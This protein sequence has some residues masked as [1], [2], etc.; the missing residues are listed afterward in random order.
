MNNS[1]HIWI[2]GDSWGVPNYCMPRPGFQSRYHISEMLGD[3]GYT[4]TN[5]AE[6]CAGNLHSIQQ[7]EKMISIS[8]FADHNP[9]W[10]IWFHTGILRDSDQ[11]QAEICNQLVPVSQQIYS[12]AAA[13]VRHTGAG[14]VMIE[15]HSPLVQDVFQEHLC[16]D[17]LISNWRGQIL[18]DPD[19]PQSHWYTLYDQLETNSGLPQ[20]QVQ[21]HIQSIDTMT[22]AMQQSALFPDC[23]HPG[24][25]AHIRLLTQLLDLFDTDQL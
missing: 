3:F 19:L 23:C 12:R 9:S 4:V 6:N 21:A 24:N 13:V 20:D 11:T 17:L 15:G 8:D 7:A 5:M 18:S 1:E 14:L 25:R 22:R 10:I 2:W 16:P